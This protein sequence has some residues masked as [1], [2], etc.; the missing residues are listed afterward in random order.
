MDRERSY[1]VFN[2]KRSG[3]GGH[4]R[5]LLFS[6]HA[7]CFVH[8]IFDAISDASICLNGHL[9]NGIDVCLLDDLSTPRSLS[10]VANVRVWLVDLGHSAPF[11]CLW[12]TTR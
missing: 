2:W 5:K 1:L 9:P 6:R 12:A 11:P 8:L 7:L 3:H 10:K 4:D